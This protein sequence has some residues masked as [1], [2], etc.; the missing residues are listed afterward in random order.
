[1][2]TTTL[3][4]GAL[5]E[6]PA[7][8]T[9]PEASQIVRVAKSFG[10]SPLRQMREMW[11]LRLSASKLQSNEYF[12]NGLF[13]PELSMA[14]KREYVGV[15][16]NRVLNGRMSPLSLVRANEFVNNK[17]L[18]TALLAQ[19]GL[20]ATRTQA[21]VLNQRRFGAVPT[22]ANADAVRD[23]LLRDATYPLF[24]KPNN[25]SLSVGSVCIKEL[26]DDRESLV[27][28][29][30][31][32]VS[33]ERFCQDVAGR[34]PMGYILQDA[35]CQHDEMTTIAGPATG[36]IRLVSVIEKDVAN[37]L[38]AV[39]KIPSPKAM[40]DNFWQAGSMIA[41]INIS[42]GQ[43]ERVR[44]GTGLDGKDVTTHPVSG[45]EFHGFQIPFWSEL[46]NLARDAHMLF[47]EFG[48][49]GFDIA[50]TRDGPAIVECNDNPFHMLYQ[51]ANQRGIKN[52]NFTAKFDRVADRANG[53]LARRSA[54]AKTTGRNK[55]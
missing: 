31:K 30:G 49:V 53:I 13:S 17:V 6:G 22:L 26:S 36:T 5:L 2:S 38:Y 51:L 21:V 20:R 10:V 8:G 42:S 25:G 14:Q 34:Y 48:V 16:S 37:P 40:S 19:M 15:K 33:V 39:W 45:R 52:P 41:A 9:A 7:Q 24:G 18:Y 50:V 28:A 1:M 3:E 32:A 35:L 54:A 11:A 47:P 27:L 44:A 29:N 12:A 55:K 23:F 46:C 43:V 4:G